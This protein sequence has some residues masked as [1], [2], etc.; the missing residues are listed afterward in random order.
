MMQDFD[1][2]FR[3]FTQRDAHPFQ[4]IF[5]FKKKSNRNN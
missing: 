1:K 5:F 2:A 3:L 4:G